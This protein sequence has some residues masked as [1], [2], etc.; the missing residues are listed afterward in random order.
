MIYNVLIY[1]EYGH[2]IDL[3]RVGAWHIDHAE[4]YV[5]N[6]VVKRYGQASLDKRF[7]L[8]PEGRLFLRVP[9]EQVSEARDA[10]FE[11]IGLDDFGL[12]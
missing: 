8:I 3:Y 5:S 7:L 11:A 6:K 9:V 1:D 12:I 2:P 10:F 4:D